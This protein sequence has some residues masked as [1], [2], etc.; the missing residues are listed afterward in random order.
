[1]GCLVACSGSAE[2]GSKKEDV[3]SKE[4]EKEQKEEIL[5]QITVSRL[6]STS[7]G[8]VYLE[9]DGKPFPLFGAQ[10]RFDVF[11]N[12]DKLSDAEVERYFKLASELNVNCVQVPITWFMVEPQEGVYD[13]SEMDLLL[14]FANKYDLKMELLWFSTNMIGDSYTYFVPSYVFKNTDVKI[15][16]GW[17]NNFHNLY[18]YY[19]GLVLDAEWLLDKEMAAVTKLFNHIRVWDSENGEKHP[20]ITCQ[21]HNEI[22]G[23]ARW[24]LDQ[25]KFTM[26][27]GTPLTEDKAWDM[28]L[29]AVDAIGQAVK[30]SS[31]RVATRVNYTSCQSV[32][33]FPQCDKAAATDALKYEGV[34]FISVDPYMTEVNDIAKVVENFTA[35][36]G[37]YPLIAENRG[38]FDTTPTLILVTAALGGGY[39][40]YDLATS[41][42]IH[43]NNGEPWGEEGVIT[44]DF[45]DRTHTP[46]VRSILKG[47]TEAGEDV[48]LTGKENF[49]AFNANKSKPEKIKTQNICTTG[50]RL[51]VNTATGAIGFILDR[52]KELVMYFTSGVNVV[53]ENGVTTDN[54]KTYKLE[55][56]KLYRI[57]FTPDKKLQSTTKTCI[58]TLYN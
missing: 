5:P 20:V 3:P 26:K 34:D 1:M 51:S 23:L 40:I 18:G 31:Y 50:A 21:L 30:A 10:I 58:G 35:P 46:L 57:G 43:D 25:D 48:A 4:E 28:T 14:I 56:E 53:V 27:D 15:S 38:F 22:D 55:G 32:G 54:V 6:A 49:M 13:F 33:I 24:R 11:R 7:S 42:F 12:C 52:G 2:N 39:D 47:L 45:K 36:E 19:H 9:V 44:Y 37:N 41:K 29:N 16:R 8:K 17:D